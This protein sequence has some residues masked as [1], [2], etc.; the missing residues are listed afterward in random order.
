MKIN[1][2]CLNIRKSFSWKWLEAWL[3]SLMWCQELHCWFFSSGSIEKVTK[4]DLNWLKACFYFHSHGINMNNSQ[5]SFQLVEESCM[6]IKW[7]DWTGCG[8]LGHREPTLSWLMKW[9]LEKPFRPLYS[10]IHF[11]KR[12]VGLKTKALLITTYY[13]QEQH[14]Y[15]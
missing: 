15:S 11:G 12:C 5:S 10:C 13:C 6:S 14:G 1:F 7:K 4:E 8:S 3:P 9:D 2:K